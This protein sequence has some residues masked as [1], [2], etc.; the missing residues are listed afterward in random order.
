[1]RARHHL[2]I[3]V[4]ALVLAVQWAPAAQ[5]APKYLD[6]DT[7]FKMESISNPQIAPDGSQVV[8]TRGFVDIMKD[9]AASNLWVIDTKGERLRQL[10]DGAFRDSAAVWSPD[11]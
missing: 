1:M 8:F 11:G 2:P 5:P 3:A 7:F 6:K 10:T 4:A 9:Q